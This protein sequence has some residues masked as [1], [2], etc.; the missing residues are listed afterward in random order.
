MEYLDN[1]QRYKK[2]REAGT[3]ISH[4]YDLQGNILA[5]RRNGRLYGGVYGVTDDLTYEYDGNRLTKVTNLAQERPAYKDA[6]YYVDWADLDTERAYDANGNMVSDADRQITRISYDRQN[7]P[8]R[9]DYLDGS[10]VDYTYDADGVKLR[11]DYYLSPYI[12]VPGDEFGIAVDSTQLVHTWREY[13][14]NCI[15][16]NDTLRM[17][18]IDGG[19]ITFEGAGRQPL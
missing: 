7:L 17:V 6:M 14:G 10:H 15:Y 11:V 18:L 12:M 19:Y 3:T 16:E 5:L 2:R 4:A 8:R 13:V 1:K 9:T